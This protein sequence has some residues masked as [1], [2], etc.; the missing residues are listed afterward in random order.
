MMNFKPFKPL[1]EMRWMGVLL[2][3]TFYLKLCQLILGMAILLL[4]ISSFPFF[5][6]IS[7]ASNVAPPANLLFVLLLVVWVIPYIWYGGRIPIEGFLLLL[8]IYIVIFTW[9]ASFFLDL[10]PFREISVLSQGR[11]AFITLL[12]ATSA[13]FIPATLLMLD[14]KWIR[15]A[16]LFINVSGGL[17]VLWS[18]IQAV[19]VFFFNSNYPEFLIRIQ[20]FFSSRGS[21]LYYARVTG[22][23]YE[24]SWLAHQ[25]VMVYLPFWL[26]ATLGGYTAIRRK[27]WH[28]SLENILLAGGVFVLFVTFS[29][30]GILSFMLILGYIFIQINIT[31]GKK[32]YRWIFIKLKIRGSLIKVTKVIIFTVLLISF[33]VVYLLTIVGLGY[34]GSFYEPRLERIFTQPLTYEGFY[35]FTNQLAFAE[36]V[37]YWSTGLAVFNDYPIFGVG[38]GNV[39]YFFPEKMPSFGYSLWEISQLFHYESHIPNTK[40][41]WVRILAETGLVGF[42]LFLLWYYVLWQSGRISQ[43]TTDPMLQVVGRFGHF[44]L[45]GFL[46]EGFSIDSFALPYFWFS[47]GLLVAAGCVSRQTLQEL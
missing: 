19:V 22:F 23:A 41:M 2:G 25:L 35:E 37:T 9:G 40:N 28:F 30:I 21:P 34:A 1:P 42:A 14:K 43:S 4:P 20:Q 47:M 3:S 5:I 11:N 27:F 6:R 12:M 45:I 7:G 44:V 32:I 38:L 10:P 24:P 46:L 18:L 39:G 31:L 29:R 8:F 13:F 33:V 26:S 15:S 16:L 36:R 17:I